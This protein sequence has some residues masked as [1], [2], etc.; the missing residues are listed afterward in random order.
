MPA[1]V[2]GIRV[3]RTIRTNDVDGWINPGHGKVSE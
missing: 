2:A 1:L 3:L